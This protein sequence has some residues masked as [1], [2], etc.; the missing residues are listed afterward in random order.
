[1]PAEHEYR[2]ATQLLTLSTHSPEALREHARRTAAWLRSDEATAWADGAYTTAL[3][4]AHLVERLALA[5]ASK[6]EAA[7][8]LAAFSE[9]RPETV[10][11]GRAFEGRRSR[12]AFVFS[13]QGPQWSGMGRAL[14]ASEPA[15]REAFEA[16]DARF[17]SLAGW[18]L[19]E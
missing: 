14:L 6:A 15:F 3:R 8:K 2:P 7:D 9:G 1:A 5:P 19:V 17:R 13:G 12:L 11:A 18:S 4:R 16:C 10:A